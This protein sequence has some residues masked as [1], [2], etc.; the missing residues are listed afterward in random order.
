MA[1]NRAGAWLM[2]LLTGCAPWQSETGL[3]ERGTWMPQHHTLKELRDLYVIKQQEDYSCGAAALAT[4]MIY[5][6]G[7][8]TSEKEILDL[9]QARLSEEDKKKT[10]LRGFSLLDLKQVAEA[11]G[12]QAAGFRL[13]MSQLAQVT[14]PVIIY[15]EPLGYK[16]FAVYRGMNQDRIYIADPARGNLR[17]SIGRFL[18]EWHGIVFV[19]GK[20]GEEKITSYPLAVPHTLYVQPELARF[21][22]LLDIGMLT[23]TLPQR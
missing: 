16:H 13:T 18:D 22:G 12:F 15:V 23:R 10:A 11:K 4:L 17:M 1:W 6:F 20:A 8:N 3:W 7:E 21:N 19:L 14:A 9:L 2:L 5:Y